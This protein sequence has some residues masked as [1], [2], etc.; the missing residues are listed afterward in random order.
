MQL[1]VVTGVTARFQGDPGGTTNYRYWV[2][3]IYVAGLGQLSAA[4]ATGA[5]AL[6]ALTKNSFV[7]VQWNPAPGAIGYLVYRNT[8]GTLPVANPIFVASSETGLKDDGTL[9]TATQPAR[10]DGIY[11]AKAYYDFAVDG[12]AIGLITPLNS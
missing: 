8:T 1:P 2:Q 3:V 10:F 4:G 9:T 11:V 6:A 12:G 7:N 5:K